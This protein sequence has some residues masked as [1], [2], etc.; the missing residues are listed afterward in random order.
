[1]SDDHS[2]AHSVQEFM[3]SCKI[4]FGILLVFTLI[5]V[6]VAKVDFGH[7]VLNIGIGL[8]IA[9]FKAFLVAAY[10]MHL[11][12]EKKLIYTVLSFTGVFFVGLMF[13][14]LYSYEDIPS[15]G[16]E[17]VVQMVESASESHEEGGHGH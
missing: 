3:R 8:L 9:T 4:V 11:I 13:L 14:T 10:F 16:R 6:A 12:S 5:T 2:G 1:M 7:H 15:T 17:P